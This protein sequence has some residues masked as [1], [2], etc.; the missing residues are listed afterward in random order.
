MVASKAGRPRVSRKSRAAAIRHAS[1]EPF[2]IDPGPDTSPDKTY[3]DSLN[4]DEQEHARASTTRSESVISLVAHLED[5]DD[6]ILNT[7]ASNG[8]YDQ[9]ASLTL[10]RNELIA[11]VQLLEA[12]LEE[13][14]GG[15][16]EGG[17]HEIW[18]S[19]STNF[20][21]AKRV[22]NGPTDRRPESTSCDSPSDIPSRS[23][24]EPITKSNF[25]THSAPSANMDQTMAAHLSMKQALMDQGD[26]VPDFRSQRPETHTPVVSD[27]NGLHRA[28]PRVDA[29]NIIQSMRGDL[30]TGASRI[31][32][33]RTMYHVNTAH[34]NSS[35][36]P[37]WTGQYLRGIET[38]HLLTRA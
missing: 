3:E 31:V 16:V 29:A 28:S 26:D 7:K 27:S 32:P 17:R 36:F 12:T 33:E 10:E 35:R 38:V 20:D 30:E 22:R 6:M 13:L 9:I 24:L 14:R 5:F 25:G 19:S 23:V 37:F 2:V 4:S 34:P 21:T 8:A 11:R 18:H 15:R 1:D